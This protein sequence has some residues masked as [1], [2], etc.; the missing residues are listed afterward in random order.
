MSAGALPSY[1]RTVAVD[2]PEV[3]SSQSAITIIDG[4]RGNRSDGW[5]RERGWSE[6]GNG[7]RAA[8]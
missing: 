7:I 1:G 5:I 6:S 2:A 4:G 3:K 8:R